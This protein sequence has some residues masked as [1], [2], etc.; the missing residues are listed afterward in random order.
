LVA[1]LFRGEWGAVC[2]RAPT[3]FVDWSFDME[4]SARG[5][6]PGGS[7]ISFIYSDTVCPQ[8]PATFKG[9]RVT[10]STAETGES[11]CSPI[12]FSE[13]TFSNGNEYAKIKLRNQSFSIRVRI[14]RSE[15][16]V[17][18]E[19]TTFMRFEALFEVPLQTDIPDFGYF[20]I[21]AETT[22]DHSDNNDLYSIRTRAQTDTAYDRTSDQILIGNRK[23]LES[24]P[25][26]RREAKRARRD[27][28]LPTLHHYLDL[29]AA[30]NNE[31]A[32]SE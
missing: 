27:A 9:F 15:G 3:V 32:R 19:Y 1:A 21:A 20:T 11:E 5:P 18:V 25:I 12:Y 14:I 10:I 17:S 31:L 7:S 6:G 23:I 2:Q 16:S 4:I 30:G 22:V 29:M 26:K 28:L 8:A 13:G 24:D